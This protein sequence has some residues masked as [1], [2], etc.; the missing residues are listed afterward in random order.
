MDKV[1]A[2]ANLVA[3]WA[4]VWA[5]KGAAGVD[6]VSIPQFQERLHHNLDRLHDELRSGTYVPQ[7][8]RRHWIPK[9]G[10]PEQRP[11][12]IPTVRDRVVQTALRMVL[13]PI[14]E[15]DFAAHSYGFR[16]KRGC[17]DALRRVVELLNAGYV[18]IVDVDLKS[19]FDT[20]PQDRLLA[21][22]GQKMADGR[23]MALIKSF[24]EQ[25][26]LD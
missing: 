22:V 6:H 13:E 2:R 1:N 14:F 7:D 5:T 11:L 17:K 10:S 20:I 9:P 18:H 19:Y 15:R 25:G 24:L 12:G 3:A 23:V 21:L 8:I 4:A 26:V 16:P